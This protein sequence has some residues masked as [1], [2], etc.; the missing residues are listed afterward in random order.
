L[1]PSTLAL[2][3]LALAYWPFDYNKGLNSSSFTTLTTL[4]PHSTFSWECA[5][6]GLN[7]ISHFQAVMADKS[8]V[9]DATPV[10]RLPSPPREYP[11]SGFE[12]VD[13][14]VLLEEERYPWYEA[15][16]WYPVRI[17]EIFKSRYQVLGKLGH[18]S[19]S[20]VWLCRDLE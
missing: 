7:S 18:G 15:E 2:Y 9:V 3:S 14:D 6:P 19:A 16:N 1:P 20:T 17:G 12:M 13:N 11:G 4:S 10:T 5:N 8:D